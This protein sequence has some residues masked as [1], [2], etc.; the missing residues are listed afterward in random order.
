VDRTSGPGSAA[1]GLKATSIE[2]LCDLS[3]IPA[4]DDEGAVDLA[5]KGDLMVRPRRQDD[6]VGL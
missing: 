4:I 1:V 2:R 5:N 6:T 3:F